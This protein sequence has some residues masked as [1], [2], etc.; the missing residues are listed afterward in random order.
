[1]ATERIHVP[2]L[3]HLVVPRSATLAD[4]MPSTSTFTLKRGD[5][6]P[7][8]QVT[9]LD[10]TGAAIDVTG[11]TIAFHMKL[12]Q[13]AA[14]NAVPLVVDGSVDLVDASN[15][16]VSYQWGSSDT[17]ETGDFVGEFVVTFADSTVRTV[18][19]PGYIPI[20]IVED[21]AA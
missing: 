3:C 13:H 4:A 6:A 10:A 19:S 12:R 8:L 9:L 17:D 21:L 15:G 7:A 2:S 5:T 16:V 20:R 18:P 14:N 11:A 1:M